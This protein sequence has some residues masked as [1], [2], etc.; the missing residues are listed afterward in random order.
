MLERYID[1]SVIEQV[2]HAIHR[3]EFQ[4]DVIDIA[5]MKGNRCPTEIYTIPERSSDHNS[6]IFR[7]S[8][9]EMTKILKKKRSL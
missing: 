2:E 3:G 9:D 6:I 4:F 1:T 5:I 7:L 8:K